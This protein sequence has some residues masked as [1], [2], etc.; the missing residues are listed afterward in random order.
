MA[1]VHTVIWPLT[2]KTVP[3]ELE[4]LPEYLM[5]NGEPGKQHLL[6]AL[7]ALVRHIRHGSSLLP[8]PEM[9]Q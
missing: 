9:I 6:V 5:A 8:S 7:E 3:I 2:D 4:G 1:P